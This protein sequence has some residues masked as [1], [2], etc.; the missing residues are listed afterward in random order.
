MAREMLRQGGRSARIQTAV[1]ETVRELLKTVDR[2][3]ITVPMI[4]EKA[5][6]TPSTIYRRWGDIGDLLADVALAHMRPISQPADTGA[7]R[8]DI[9]TFIVEYAEEMSS[10]LGREMLQDIVGSSSGGGA[11]ER[12]CH[13][14]IHHLETL[15]DR[16]EQRGEAVFDVDAAMD[17]LVAPIVYHIMFRDRD[18]TPD[19]CRALISEFLEERAGN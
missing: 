19:Y 12:C 6:V 4:A 1:H 8:T 14:T 16:A 3:A 10:R 13:Y 11:A 5:G 7:M 17:K 9:E 18:V 15:R 2:S